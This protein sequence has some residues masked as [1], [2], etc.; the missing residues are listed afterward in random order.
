MPKE[1]Q[2]MKIDNGRTIP[3]GASAKYAT[4]LIEGSPQQGW[5]KMVE[6][7]GDNFLFQGGLATCDPEVVNNLL[8]KRAHTLKR[9]AIYKLTSKIIPAPLASYSWTESNGTSKSK[10]SCPYLPRPT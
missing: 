7:Y 8:M 5:V 10:L 4:E 2:V 9:S 1:T 6:T 3:Q